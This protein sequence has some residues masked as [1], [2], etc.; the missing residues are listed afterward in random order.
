MDLRAPSPQ[1]GGR[2]PLWAQLPRIA[3]VCLAFLLGC[4]EVSDYDIWWHLRTGELIPQNGVPQKDWYTFKSE[5]EAWIDVHW[6]FQVIA[7]GLH[8][9]FGA[10]GLVLLKAALGAIA[11]GVALSAYRNRW[12][13]GVHVA[14]WLPAIF[15]MSARFYER[16]EMFTLVFTAIYLAILF[17]AE[18][19]PRLLWLLP[20]AQAAWANVQGLFVFGPIL[21]A[22][23]W[24]EAVARESKVQGLFRHLMPVTL[25]VFAACLVSPYGVKNALL[26]WQISQTATSSA[27]RNTIAELKSVPAL[28]EE[29]A[30]FNPYV[31]LLGSLMVMGTVSILCAWRTVLGELRF[32]RVLPFAAF[33]YLGLQ[34]VRNGNHFALVAGATCAWN[35][36]SLRW[37]GGSTRRNSLGWLAAI[38]VCGWLVFTERWHLVASPQRKLGFG[39]RSLYYAH[40]AMKLAGMPGMPR[41]AY[42]VHSGHSATY[43]YA[44]Y[45]PGADRKVFNDAR[46]EVH[47]LRTYNLYLEIQ[48]LLKRGDPKAGILL[49]QDQ[50]QLVGADGEHNFDVQGAMLADVDWVCIHFDPI[51][52]LFVRK[53]FSLP[54]AVP[55][56]DLRAKLFE[57]PPPVADLPATPPSPPFWLWR[58]PEN[59]DRGMEDLWSTRAAFC[60]SSYVQ[61]TSHSPTV[62]RAL[63]LRAVRGGIA[64]VAR[65][66]WHSES[67]RNLGAAAFTLVLRP[68][69]PRESWRPERQLAAAFALRSLRQALE[70]RG[71]DF[72]ANYYAA[73]LYDTLDA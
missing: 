13:V 65:R 24:V 48:G 11:V 63:C 2:L 66:P 34:A 54:P 29:G 14:V 61:R 64:A 67:Y 7:A 52:A 47:S 58:P 60:A 12:P 18:E 32:F 10:P 6:G 59:Y 28:V 68:P 72:S 27:Y 33:S 62:G 22:M 43:I 71:G 9:A 56:I 42:I 53:D 4:F 5:D 46:L 38:G 35:F 44:N 50:V 57:D 49:A 23:Y 20:L 69:P 25:L 40:D 21:L 19:R 36:G 73:Q 16:P 8:S 37:N 17:R 31:W 45:S 41:R 55:P 26:V 1:L 70:L 30:Y 15:L 39:E 3:L 51:Y